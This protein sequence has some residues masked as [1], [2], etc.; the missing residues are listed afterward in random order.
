MQFF[1]E[2]NHV[3]FQSSIVCFTQSCVVSRMEQEVL[4]G[5]VGWLK[6]N[7]HIEGALWL[8]QL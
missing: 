4:Q 3:H 8:L 5:T 7:V 6:F 1:L 2:N